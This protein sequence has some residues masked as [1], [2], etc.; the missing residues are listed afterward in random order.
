M[1]KLKILIGLALVFAMCDA[2][3]Q[4]GK[5]ELASAELSDDMKD[6]AQQL[7]ARVGLSGIKSDDDFRNDIVKKAKSYDIALTPDE[8]TVQRDGKG[9]WANMYFAANYT[10]SVNLPGYSFDM[11]FNPASGPKPN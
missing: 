1:G 7:G 3:W 2:G 10:E 5:Y 4:I 11:H 9:M 6:M 8:V